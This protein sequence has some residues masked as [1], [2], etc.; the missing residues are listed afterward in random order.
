MGIN[1]RSKV[2]AFRS[3]IIGDDEYGHMGI[4][5][6]VI[7]ISC[8]GRREEGRFAPNLLLWSQYL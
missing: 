8:G 5:Y 3:G 1:K 2:S 7:V 4:S 6:V